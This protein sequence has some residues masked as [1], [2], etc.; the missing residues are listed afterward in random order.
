MTSGSGAYAASMDYLRRRLLARRAAG[1][2]VDDD[3]KKHAPRRS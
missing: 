2:I 3:R 1:E